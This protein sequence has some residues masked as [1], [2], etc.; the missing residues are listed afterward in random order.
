MY[1]QAEHIIIYTFT[2]LPRLGR[3]LPCL[4]LLLVL[5]VV[6]H[7]TC[8]SAADNLDA[9]AVKPYVGSIATN[10]PLSVELNNAVNLYY[11]SDLDVAADGSSKCIEIVN[12]SKELGGSWVNFVPTLFWSEPDPTA[13][14]VQSYCWSEKPQ[15]SFCNSFTQA[16]INRLQKG[17]EACFAAAVVAGFSI[18]ITPHLDD[19]QRLG[20][21]RNLLVFDPTFNLGG[22]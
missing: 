21:W 15:S 16:D 20:R 13:Y 19:G 22:V 8:F 5:L 1:K 9:A 4:S 18:A 12:R 11:M 14:T 17:Y 2:M 10:G 3:T 7:H 6:S